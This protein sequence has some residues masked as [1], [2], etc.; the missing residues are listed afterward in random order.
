M[1]IY[2]II[3]VVVFAG[4]IGFQGKNDTIL[5]TGKI[6][7]NISETI[8]ITTPVNGICYWA[9]RDT[10]RLDSS[11]NFRITLHA[12]KPTI[13][14]L[15]VSGK[16]VGSVV[17]EPGEN[18]QVTM[19]PGGKG[20][21]FQVLGKSA[22]G[23]ELYNKFPITGHIQLG[24]REFFK[25]S[26]ASV[27]K[28]KIQTA[29]DNTIRGFQELHKT[30]DI[31]KD[32]L[33]LVQSDF[34][35]YYAAIQG[36]VALIK[37][38]MEDRKPGSYTKGIEDMWKEAV[39]DQLL[40][41]PEYMRSPNYYWLVENYLFFK[42]YTDE[43]FNRDK[44]KEISVKGLMH[45]HNLEQAKKNLSGERLEYYTA[46]YICF[47][48][49]QRQYEKELISLFEEFRK[50]YPASAYTKYLEP[51]VTPIVDY[52]QKAAA[53]FSEKVKFI[54]G[55]GNIKSLEEAVK[56]LKGKKIF[57]DVWAT[58]CG[59]CKAEFEYKDQLKKL[60]EPKNIEVLY[61]SIDRDEAD[62]QWKDMIKYYNLEGSHIRANRELV[63][64]LRKIYN[65]NGLIAIPW[66][67]FIDENGTIKIDHAA[68]PSNIKELEK[69]INGK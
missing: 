52:H 35:C 39:P 20:N 60:L 57:V 13:V 34:E 40:A 22:K 47:A 15:F 58:W 8:E 17:A 19:E 50:D 37:K 18:Y 21:N 61:I 46:M 7:G 25:D 54:E 26:V 42:E 6:T 38:Y 63:E 53:G 12:V 66:Y 33:S 30:G 27:I 16:P 64:D 67:I 28:Q 14:E 24:A 65:Q 10:V 41:N 9:F 45:T 1:K 3:L 11:G 51:L 44:L 29:R 59:P 48:S 31:S 5:I 36:T 2:Q 62:K 32:F 56:S 4:L 55:Y 43:S 68:S 49:M 23:Q 69:Q